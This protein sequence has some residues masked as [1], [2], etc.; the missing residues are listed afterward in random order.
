VRAAEWIAGK[1]GFFD[2]KDVWREI[3]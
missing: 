1:Q 2:F 3:P